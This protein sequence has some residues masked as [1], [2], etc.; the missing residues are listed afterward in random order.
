MKPQTKIIDLLL[1]E[2]DDNHAELV[3]RALEDR[4]GQFRLRVARSLREAR[5][6]IG[7]TPPDLV[8]ADWRL[9][10]GKG[11]EI[12]PADRT[13]VPFPLVLMTSYG[14]EQLV[15]EVIKSGALDYVVKSPDSLSEIPHTAERALREWDLICARRR[16]EE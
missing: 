3:R 12:L 6:F 7:Q 11:L 16:E 5:I 9:P 2:D 10:D 4:T 15:V 8:I 1:I 14:N 13:S